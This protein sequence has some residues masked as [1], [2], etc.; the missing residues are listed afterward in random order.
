MG[1]ADRDLA[2]LL[3]FLRYN[4]LTAIRLDPIVL[5]EVM[6]TVEII[7]TASGQTVPLPEEFHFKTPT[8]SIRRQGDA[9]ILEPLKAAPWPVHFFD[10]IQIND[11]AFVR[12]PQGTYRS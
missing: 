10:S 1:F 7:E 6:K 5:G 11:P 8:I 2:I 4:I 9:V 3:F 12:P